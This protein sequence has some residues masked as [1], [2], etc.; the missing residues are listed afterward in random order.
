MCANSTFFKTYNLKQIKLILATILLFFVTETIAK[1]IH[2]ENGLTTSTLNKDELNFS[3][4]SPHP[5]IIANEEDFKRVK[6]LYKN[7]SNKY[8]TRWIDVRLAKAKELLDEKFDNPESNSYIGYYLYDGVRTNAGGR[9]LGAIK[10]LSFAYIMTGEPVYA[11]KVWFL[12]KRAGL[13]EKGKTPSEGL[14]P[15]WYPKFFLDLSAMASAYAIGYDWCYDYFSEAQRAFIERTI[16]EYGLNP[17]FELMTKDSEAFEMRGNHN[18]NAVKNTGI[19]LAALS[20]ADKYPD[21]TAKIIKTGIDN[22]QYMMPEFAP[23]GAWFESVSY[24][25]YTIEYFVSL[26][27]SLIKA[28]GDDSGLM[29]YCGLK[30][31]GEFALQATGPLGANSYH[32]GDDSKIFASC[33]AIFWLAK[34]FGKHELTAA[35]LDFMIQNNMDADLYD[36]LW[37]D[38]TISRPKTQLEKDAYF[39]GVEFVSMR[40]EWGNPESTWVSFHGGPGEGS[41][42]HMDGG[43]FVY[44]ALGIRWACDLHSE[45]YNIGGYRSFT[46]SKRSYYRVRTEGHNTLVINPDKSV[47]QDLDSFMKVIKYVPGENNP[48]SVLDMTSGYKNAAY[49]AIRGYMLTDSRNSLVIRDELE[50]KGNHSEIYW[51]M[52]T[53]ADAKVVGKDKVILT[54]EGKKMELEFVTNAEE[55]QI[56]IVPAEPLPSS[57]EPF[58]GKQSD[59]SEYRKVQIRLLGSGKVNLTVKLKPE[60]NEI[61]PVNDLPI[62]KW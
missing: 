28:L 5:R 6:H 19:I 33:P 42:A 54:K 23:D 13:P 39:G 60:S 59:N 4:R 36:I 41:H 8:L 22:I 14:F 2:P 53:Q 52:H 55:A 35:K 10:E 45:N 62:S 7:K 16:I 47:G 38:T 17:A 61:Q 24:W 44:D 18:R 46:E 30:R 48:F 25:N 56:A 11:Q 31:T 50:L 1:E 37:Y 9:M 43:A 26:V 57:P 21:L 20:V 15:D 3:I 34:Y 29:D 58:A 32:D 51:F 12:L 49:R 40:K 27:S